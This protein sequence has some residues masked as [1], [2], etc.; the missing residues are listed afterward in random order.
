VS[1]MKRF[2][3]ARVGDIVYCRIKGLGTI[4]RN[5]V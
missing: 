4:T 1:L 5:L 3:N 2:E